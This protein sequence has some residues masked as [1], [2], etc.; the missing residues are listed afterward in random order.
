MR[1]TT[2][3]NLDDARYKIQAYYSNFR[4]FGSSFNTY[5]KFF[6]SYSLS[7]SH[8]HPEQAAAPATASYSDFMLFFFPS[9]VVGSAAWPRVCSAAW[10]VSSNAFRLNLLFRCYKQIAMS[11]L[12]SFIFISNGDY[13][14][15][16]GNEKSANTSKF[17]QFRLAATVLLLLAF[18]RIISLVGSSFVFVAFSAHCFHSR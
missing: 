18:F 17:S 8:S 3:P 7:L 12:H 16:A 1:G 13:R 5:I 14:R 15:Q 9:S 6:V 2:E 11:S 10:I 4:W